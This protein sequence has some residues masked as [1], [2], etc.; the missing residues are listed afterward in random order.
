MEYLR[1]RGNYA[2]VPTAE[3]Q[4]A[5]RETYPKLYQL[6]RGASRETFA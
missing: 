5:F 4:K 3:I 2:D 1:D 6:G